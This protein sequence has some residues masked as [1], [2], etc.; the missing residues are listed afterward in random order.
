M[1]NS[2]LRIGNLVKVNGE[3]VRVEQI[4]KKKIGYHKEPRENVMHYARFVEVVPI[5][6]TEEIIKKI[7]AKFKNK[8]GENITYILIEECY[9]YIELTITDF[10]LHILTL[11]NDYK[12]CVIDCIQSLSELQNWYYMF[13]NEE[14]E[15]E[16]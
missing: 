7:G 5:E 8:E 13:N 6:I 10:G 15:V 1:K 11:K 9:R 14:L 12:G 16:L 4:T 3:I 2:E